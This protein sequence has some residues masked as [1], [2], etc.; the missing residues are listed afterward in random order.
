MRELVNPDQ[1]WVLHN[2]RQGKATRAFDTSFVSK[3]P[4]AWSMLRPLRRPFRAA[5]AAAARPTC[6]SLPRLRAFVGPL[7]RCA[8]RRLKL[9]VGCFRILVMMMMMMLDGAVIDQ[10]GAKIIDA[11]LRDRRRRRV[12]LILG[13]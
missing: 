12:D 11:N 10:R 9:M 4:L 13:W 6:C 2:W 1:S 3:F 5:A 7:A 8:P